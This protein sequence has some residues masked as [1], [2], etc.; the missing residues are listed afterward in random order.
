M[1]TEVLVQKFI[2][3]K[4]LFSLFVFLLLAFV[5]LILYIDLSDIWVSVGRGETIF[6]DLIFEFEIPLILLL[7]S[8][9]HFYQIKNLFIRFFFPIIPIVILYSLF[10]AFY[11]IL[12]RS[13]YP[14]DFQ[15]FVSLWTFSPMMAT[16]LLLIFLAISSIIFFLLYQSYNSQPS[17]YFKQS[18]FI[19][20]LFISLTA[21]TLT[22]DSFAHFHNK[23]FRYYFWSQE[24][25]VRENGKFSSFIYYYN[26]ERESIK[27]LENFESHHTTIDI[28]ETLYPGEITA[29]RLFI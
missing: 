18:L 22:T 16:G 13:P 8:F 11:N 19:R 4:K 29:Q 15:N 27:K 1:T 20:T 21:F 25:T 24:F 17:A 6:N 12:G 9:F 23:K 7:L 14:S 26:Q 2:G 3:I 5:T 28:Q 10:D